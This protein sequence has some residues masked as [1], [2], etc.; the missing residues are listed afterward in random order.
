MSGGKNRA[1]AIARMPA[2][3]GI[4]AR[5]PGVNRPITM[6]V[7]P[8]RWNKA[9]PRSASSGWFLSGQSRNAASL[10]RWPNQ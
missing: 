10:Y 5:T 1:G 7:P 6:L 3:I 8:R 9:A 2:S 4:T